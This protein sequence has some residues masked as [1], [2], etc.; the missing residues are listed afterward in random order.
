[1]ATKTT[2]QKRTPKVVP[3]ATG[4]DGSPLPP[5]PPPP[6]PAAGPVREPSKFQPGVQAVGPVVHDPLSGR[7]LT[8]VPPHMST[9]VGGVGVAEDSRLRP[10]L[11]T[12][13]AGP[14]GQAQAEM[15]SLI[16]VLE[17]WTETTSK[18]VE[19]TESMLAAAD[20]EQGKFY[21]A[22]AILAEVQPSALADLTGDL[23]EV[24]EAHAALLRNDHVR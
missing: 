1:M 13:Q 17:R 21:A 18:L 10:L 8:P 16:L 19:L 2:P 14:A 22:A 3:A 20:G 6:M 9:M 24:L 7:D 15:A 11:V 4:P 5:V 12:P 23:K